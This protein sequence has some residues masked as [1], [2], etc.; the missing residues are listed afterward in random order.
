VTNN[1]VLYENALKRGPFTVWLNEGG[2]EAE[3]TFAVAADSVKPNKDIKLKAR[4]DRGRIVGLEN[5]VVVTDPDKKAMIADRFWQNPEWIRVFLARSIYALTVRKKEQLGRMV[6]KIATKKNDEISKETEVFNREVKKQ[7]YN[8][9][10]AATENGQELEVVHLHT[11]KIVEDEVA[12]E[13]GEIRNYR[14]YRDQED[15][16]VFSYQNNFDDNDDLLDGEEKNIP[17]KWD[18]QKIVQGSYDQDGQV[19]WKPNVGDVYASAFFDCMRVLEFGDIVQNKDEY[20]GT[21]EDK[22]KLLE[23]SSISQFFMTGSEYGLL[24]APYDRFF[25]S[26]GISI[27]S[28]MVDIPKW[29]VKAEKRGELRDRFSLN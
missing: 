12:D 3:L 8:L 1:K 28:A 26:K 7:A 10:M 20:P 19:L 22:E 5:V 2:G 6:T 25:T 14:F 13:P 18:G 24:G 17:I 29:V 4:S 9:L 11:Y 27:A 23:C 21:T 15:N 16:L